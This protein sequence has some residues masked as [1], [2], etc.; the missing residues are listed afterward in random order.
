M[1]KMLTIIV[2]GMMF[3]STFAWARIA[4]ADRVVIYHYDCRYLR[5]SGILPGAYYVDIPTEGLVNPGPYPYQ[6]YLSTQMDV[7]LRIRHELYSRGGVAGENHLSIFVDGLSVLEAD[8]PG[9]G[10]NWYP[11]GYWYPG[12]DG[13]SLVVLGNL[14]SG[15]HYITMK[16]TESDYYGVNWWEIISPPPV[17]SSMS[18]ICSPNPVSVDSPALCTVTVSGSSPTGTVVWSMN[19]RTGSFGQYICDLSDGTCSTTFTDIFPGTVN[20]T[21]IYSGDVNNAPSSG[22][23]TLTETAYQYAGR[24]HF[25]VSPAFLGLRVNDTFTVT[26]DLTNAENLVCWQVVLKYSGAGLKLNEL[27]RP[28]DSVFAGHVVIAP[29]VVT[30]G[31]AM[32]GLSSGEICVSLLDDDVIT[33]VDNGVLFKANFTVIAPGQWLIE[34]ADI[35]HPLVPELHY[36]G[37]ISYSFWMDSSLSTQ[38]VAP[39][40]NCTVLTV[41]PLVG[42]V[43]GDFRVDIRDIAVAAKA[44][45]TVSGDSRWNP[46]A[47]VNR[48]GKVDLRDVALIAKNFGQHWP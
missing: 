45:G 12:G 48:D 32:D 41:S 15:T 30:A 35:S 23:T 33:K 10:L 37:Y 8:S 11:G 38:N 42:D 22:C 18:I 4:R 31:D 44:F 40:S 2:I 14:S 19:S 43:N 21:A 9:N 20:I 25:L 28:D 36:L 16:A 29:P 27:W 47:D 46:A 34:V 39:G 26:V 6:F 5:V 13:E 24:A 1:K 3:L 17:Q 7:A